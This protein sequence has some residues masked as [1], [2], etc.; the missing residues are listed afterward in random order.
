MAK[1]RK[2]KAP[3]RAEPTALKSHTNRKSPA[4]GK[5]Y[6]RCQFLARGEQ[7]PKT[8]Y[9]DGLCWGH[10]RGNAP[11]VHSRPLVSFTIDLNTGKPPKGFFG[12]KD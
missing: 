1:D 2:K 9:S 7:C 5:R 10:Y 3:K 4:T 11:K 12:F 6:P 8:A